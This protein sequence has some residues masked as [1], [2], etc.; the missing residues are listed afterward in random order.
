MNPCRGLA[1][2]FALAC[3][4]ANGQEPAQRLA[5]RAL[6]DTPLVSDLSELCDGIG[7]RPTGSAACNRAVE[8][9][10]K[11]FRE[12]G[13][14]SV[15]T[16]S[17]SVPHL[18]LPGSA[19]AQAIA[20]EKFDIR[21]AAAP[22]SPS[23]TGTI[24][25]PLVDAGEAKSEELAKIAASLKGAILL[26]RSQEMKTFDDLFAEYV[27]NGS[28]LDAA[29]K[30]QPA[31]IL[32]EST[33]PRGLLYRHP[34]TFDS[35]LAPA[36][37]AVISRENAERLGRLA[38]HQQVKVR[39]SLQN[40]TGGEYESKNVIAEIRGRE[41]P[42]EVVLIGAHLDSWDLGTGAE[43]NGVNA[44]MVIDAL[45]GFKQLGLKPRRTIR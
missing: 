33:R 35:S 37:M 39:L 7:G 6:G 45:R 15:K 14:D 3:V 44:A 32:L 16:E 40:R 34:V 30:Y 38:Q 12:A 25:A 18:W 26:V 41:K 13:A 10:A 23:T 36:P 1:V 4:N 31:A 24:E 20:P 43:D 8:W 19:E 22:F 29:K 21:I 2:V 9:A 42:N 5:A 28:L 17:F 27:R 11:K